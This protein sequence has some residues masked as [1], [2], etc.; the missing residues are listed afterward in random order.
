MAFLDTQLHLVNRTLRHAGQ[1]EA[2]QHEEHQIVALAALGHD[3]RWI[4]AQVM[5][6]REIEWHG[7]ITLGAWW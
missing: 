1:C 7:D 4:G 6:K 3:I 5:I 2:R